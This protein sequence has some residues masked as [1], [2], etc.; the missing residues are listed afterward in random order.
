MQVLRQADLKGKERKG[1]HWEWKGRE[2]IPAIHSHNL[3]LLEHYWKGRRA[4]VLS[5][6]ALQSQHYVQPK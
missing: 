4:I 1:N 5:R 2:L 6:C 3:T